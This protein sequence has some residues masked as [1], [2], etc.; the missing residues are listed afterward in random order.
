MDIPKTVKIRRIVNENKRVKTFFLDIDIKAK[1]GQFIML[2][3]PGVDEKPFSL[4][5]IGKETAV[6][7]EKKG[8]FTEKLFKLKE[9]DCV[10]IRGPYGRGFSLRKN[11]CVVAGGLGIA[12]LKPLIERLD[13]PIIV[14]GVKTKDDFI[15]KNTFTGVKLCT[16]D[17]CVGFKGF[18]TGKIEEIIG[19]QR[20]DI[21]YTCGPEI[22]M[23]KLFDI[24]EKHDVEV[25]AS[26]ERYIRCGFGV[27]GSCV[28][29]D[30]LVCKDGPVFNSMQLR[31]MEEFGK[32][33]KTRTGQTISL[34]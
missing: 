32:S 18:A 14:Y 17:G 4:S 11:A 25:E 31:K 28:C 21:V 29:D 24:C 10:G 20:F 27:C 15:F 6:T 19:K 8:I 16:E 5:Y 1:P 7:I 2:W 26:L 12:P 23:K 13:N 3:L 33:T 34:T 22:M 30:Q 9:N